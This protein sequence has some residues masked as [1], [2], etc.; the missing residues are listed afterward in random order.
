MIHEVMFRF[1]TIAYSCYCYI[2]DL[3][4]SLILI[5]LW[6]SDDIVSPREVLMLDS[7]FGPL[8]IPSWSDRNV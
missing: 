3:T 1:F 2:Y 6:P 5:L 8:V 4:C 7:G